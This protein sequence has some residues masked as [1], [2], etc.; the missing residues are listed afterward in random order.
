MSEWGSKTR[1]IRKKR[2]RYEKLKVTQ[3]G[4]LCNAVYKGERC[5]RYGDKNKKK[6]HVQQTHARRY[7]ATC[8]SG[9]A[10]ERGVGLS[11]LRVLYWK[12][13]NGNGIQE[14]SSC[15]EIK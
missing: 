2:K 9:D 12:G 14:G 8:R 15:H 10:V 6:T 1:K 13:R 5:I 11:L 7:E 4:V 3:I